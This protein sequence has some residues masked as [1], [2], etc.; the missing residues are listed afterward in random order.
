MAQ[1]SFHTTSMARLQELKEISKQGFI[2]SAHSNGFAGT[3]IGR[4]ISQVKKTEDDISIWN[5]NDACSKEFI[6]DINNQSLKIFKKTMYC[7]ADSINIYSIEMLTMFQKIELLHPDIIKLNH[8]YKLESDYYIG[9][10]LEK[11]NIYLVKIPNREIIIEKINNH[12]FGERWNL[13][14]TNIIELY[15][16]D[17]PQY[18]STFKID[19][20]NNI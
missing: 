3:F 4:G 1:A 14:K 10:I 11:F 12:N 6:M 8:K 20:L 17:F 13:K 2:N 5:F 18:S 15:S 19:G 7:G 16:N 9:T